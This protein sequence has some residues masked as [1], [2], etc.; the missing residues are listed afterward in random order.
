MK[1]SFHDFCI[2]SG[3]LYLLEQWHPTKN[4][5]LTPKNVGKSSNKII[6]WR[7]EY[8]HEWRTQANSRT[9]GTGCPECYRQKMEQKR[10]TNEKSRR[11]TK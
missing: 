6:W 11:N 2:S 8:G 9:K 3:R 5:E 1:I 7:C 10:W 4:G